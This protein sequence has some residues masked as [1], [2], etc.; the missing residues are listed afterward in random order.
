[1]NDSLPVGAHLVTP[2]NWYSHH[3]IHVGNGRV[4]HYAGYCKGLLHR[5]PVEEVSLADF[6]RGH[7]FEVRSHPASPFS[8][9][10]I[11]QRA[12]NRVGEDCYRLLGNNC[13]HFCEWCVTGASRSE[14]VERFLS[15]PLAILRRFWA[16]AS[17]KSA[18]AA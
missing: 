5:G 16:A 17:P 11:A 4:V 9:R 15:R 12:R 18:P 7:G 10:E 8:P 2:R 6:A 1:M 13:E 14:Q 3:G